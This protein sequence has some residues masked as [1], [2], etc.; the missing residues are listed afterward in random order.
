MRPKRP[1]S[2]LLRDLAELLCEAADDLEHR[3]GGESGSVKGPPAKR[4]GPTESRLLSREQA[5]A[6]LGIAPDLFDEH[7][8]RSPGIREIKI[9]RRVLFDR[10]GLDAW[11]DARQAD[12]PGENASPRSGTAPV[13]ASSARAQQIRAELLGS[14]KPRGRHQVMSPKKRD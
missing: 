7:V 2:A 3:R 10:E 9:G 8:R 11:I 13:R 1:L 14:P 5:A 4:R 12:A 6:H